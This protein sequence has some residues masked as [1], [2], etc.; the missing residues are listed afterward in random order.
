MERAAQTGY[1]PIYG[2]PAGVDNLC[3]FYGLSGIGYG[4]LRLAE[5]QKLPSILLWE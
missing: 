3:F 1:T 2:L 5:R 4:L